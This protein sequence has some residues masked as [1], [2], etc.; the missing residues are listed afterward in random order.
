MVSHFLHLTVPATLMIFG[1][2]G[3]LLYS[4]TSFSSP[5]RLAELIAGALL[6]ALGSLAG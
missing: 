6:L 3:F 5:S 4:A 1:F 2:G